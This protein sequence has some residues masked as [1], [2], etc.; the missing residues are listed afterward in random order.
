MRNQDP[1]FDQQFNQ[2]IRIGEREANAA[3]RSFQAHSDILRGDA[4]G[5]L[6]RIAQY[7]K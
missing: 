2:A 6:Y 3:L 5:L 1:R 4:E 7:R